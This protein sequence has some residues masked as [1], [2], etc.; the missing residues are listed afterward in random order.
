M[1]VGTNGDEGSGRLPEGMKGKKGDVLTFVVN[2]KK[3][4]A[5]CWVNEKEAKHWENQG[6]KNVSKLPDKIF[7][8][9]CLTK[10]VKLTI[11]E[12]PERYLTL[13]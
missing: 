1:W 3:N 13:V 2:F 11:R 6:S 12:C 5:K 9:V 4:Q 7:P 8:V 10:G